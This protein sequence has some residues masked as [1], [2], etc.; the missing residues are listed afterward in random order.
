M[1]S[2]LEYEKNLEKT[3]L[4]CIIVLKKIQKNHFPSAGMTAGSC[5]TIKNKG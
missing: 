1:S 3:A 4:C 2:Y 5:G